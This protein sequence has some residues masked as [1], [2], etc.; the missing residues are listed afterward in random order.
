[1][2][3]NKEHMSDVAKETWRDEGH[4]FIDRFLKPCCQVEFKDNEDGGREIKMRE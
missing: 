3:E 4:Y 1:M 2:V